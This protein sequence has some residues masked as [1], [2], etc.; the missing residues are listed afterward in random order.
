MGT[1]VLKSVLQPMREERST[2][3]A[4]HARWSN[5]GITKNSITAIKLN[6]AVFGAG[7][8]TDNSIF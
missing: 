3:G 5:V 8:F 7:I 2:G 4:I 1:N 6:T